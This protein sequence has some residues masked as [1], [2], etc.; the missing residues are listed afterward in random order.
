M[1]EVIRGLEKELEQVVRQIPRLEMARRDDIRKL[2]RDTAMF[3]VAQSIDE[4]RSKC[5]DL[6]RVL[7]HLEAA[8][9]DLVDN[10]MLF[11]MKA[12][13]DDEKSLAEF[14][15][16]NPFQRYEVNVLVTH[17]KEG[18]T[19]PIVEELHPTLGNLL[20]NIEYV[21]QHGVLFTNFRQ[22]KA[23][24]MHRASGGYLLLDVRN[25]LME[26]FSWAALKRTLRQGEIKIED[27]GHFLGLTSTVSIEPD[28]IPLNI[29]VILFGDRI[30]YYLLASLDP[31]VRQYFKVLADFEDDVARSPAT[32]AIHARLLTSIVR[33]KGLR[34]IDR[35]GVALVIEHAARVADHA[36]KL[37][38][39]I[40]QVG[41]LL[42]EA[43]C[44]A[45][46]AKH[47]VIGRDDI[48]RALDEKVHR[49]SR[50]RDRAQESILQDVAL[51]DTS[52]SSL[53]QVNGLSVL[54]LGG[55]RF[56]RRR[57]SPAG[58]G[59]AAARSWT[60][61]ARWNWVVRSTPRAC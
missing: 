39:L 36:G 41:D 45:S 10:V 50:L 23:G 16:G 24:A 43:D 1:Q 11:V 17:T 54:E 26:P 56:G 5:A 37:T 4:V 34:P 47:D 18:S 42:A 46:E 19:T 31:E 49:S 55:F 20:G 48:Q 12:D 21:S 7:D 30:L 9:G 15:G 33:S 61:S 25:L 8:R 2:N 27:V 32:E 53:G 60:S 35:D 44:W 29:K 38:L 3:A 6:P 57:A 52:G 40:D 14:Q 59:P 22:I 28:P 58:S 51:I 13:D